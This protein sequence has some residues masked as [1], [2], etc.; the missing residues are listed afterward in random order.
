MSYERPDKLEEALAVLARGPARIAAGCTDLFAAT[1]DKALRGD[2]L[3]L[4]GVAELRGITARQGGGLRIG[5]TTTWADIARAGLPPALHSLQ[6]AARQVGAHQVQNRGTLAGN[7]CNASPAADGVPPLLTLDA[8]VELVS[9][10]GVRVLALPEFILGPRKTALAPGEIVSAVLLPEAALSGASTFE[11]LGARAYLVI[12][13]AML[14]LRLRIEAGVIAEIAC[15]VGA[16]GPVAS[17]LSGVEAGLT[18]QPAMA[19]AQIA[20]AEITAGLAPITDMRADA[21]YRLQAVGPLLRRAGARLLA[22][23]E[24][25]A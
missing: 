4:T 16:C 9:A 23:E 1:E 22:A 6:E 8:E 3:D 25:A 13:I 11:K 12:S 15:A 19:L 17:R 20:D 5:G 2:V 7:L 14:A 24:A 18:G 10:D 21:E